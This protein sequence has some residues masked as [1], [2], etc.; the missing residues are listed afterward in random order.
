MV[1]SFLFCLLDS[2]LSLL[3]CYVVLFDCRHRFFVHRIMELVAYSTCFTL[4]PTLHSST[5]SLCLITGDSCAFS[6][7][8]PHH[9]SNACQHRWHAFCPYKSLNKVRQHLLHGKFRFQEK[10]M[11]AATTNAAWW[12]ENCSYWS[13]PPTLGFCLLDIFFHQ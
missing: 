9:S 8:N 7:G 2:C 1:S 10:K 12:F 13:S 6:R 11:G 4:S 3:S 5:L